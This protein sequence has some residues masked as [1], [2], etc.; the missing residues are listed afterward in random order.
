MLH[1]SCLSASR[2]SRPEQQ[3]ARQT[4]ILCRSAVRFPLHA[5]RASS[6]ADRYCARSSNLQHCAAGADASAGWRGVSGA[7]PPPTAASH[8][9]REPGAVG[10]CCCAASHSRARS[11]CHGHGAARR[12]PAA[13]GCACCRR[14]WWCGICPGSLPRI[15]SG[16]FWWRG[17]GCK[18]PHATSRRQYSG[19][20]GPEPRVAAGMLAA[21]RSRVTRVTLPVLDIWWSDGTDSVIELHD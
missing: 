14:F 9:L 5:G 17:G 19:C 6:M 13:S 12:A 16:P 15:R 21:V 7:I 4:R 18:R 10:R 11:S 20:V 2:Y 8:R 3:R 1:A